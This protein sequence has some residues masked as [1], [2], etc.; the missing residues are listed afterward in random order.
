MSVY[1]FCSREFVKMFNNDEFI[2][3]QSV[4]VLRHCHGYCKKLATPGHIFYLVN[5]INIE[6]ISNHAANKKKI[7]LALYMRLVARPTG[8]ILNNRLNSYNLFKQQI[9][10]ILKYDINADV[11]K[12][13]KERKRSLPA[14]F[15]TG[16]WF[17]GNPAT[18]IKKQIVLKKY[19]NIDWNNQLDILH[20]FAL[21]CRK[22]LDGTEKYIK[23][24][25]FILS[26][27]TTKNM[28]KLICYY[29]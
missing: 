29:V 25:R 6:Y 23:L 19:L 18:D 28:T 1:N 3:G 22:Q 4:L 15:L 13:Y 20:M 24:V 21:K 9:R 26:I 17:Q 12:F 7:L 16:E 10:F 2:K 27:F 5:F 14:T 11:Y 8:I